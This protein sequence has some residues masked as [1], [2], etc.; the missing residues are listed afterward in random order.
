MQV[1]RTLVDILNAIDITR[2]P[3]RVACA[4]ADDENLLLS[5]RTTIARGL[6]KP[7]LIGPQSQIL[8][9]ASV[10]GLEAGT[11]EVIDIADKEEACAQ[12][13]FLCQQGE[14][15]VI[16]KGA[17]PTS[18]LL[19]AVLRSES[20]S[21]SRRTLTHVTVFRPRGFRRLMVLADAGVQIAPNTDDLTEIV[22]HAARLAC[23]LGIRRPKVAMLSAAEFINPKMPSSVIA[24]EVAGLCSARSDITADVGGPYALDVAVS[25]VA[26]RQKGMADGIAGRADVL[27]T[28]GID[29]GNVLYKSLTSFSGLDL[30]SVVVG[31]VMP[32]IIPSRADSERTKI[33]STA[34]AL[35][36]AQNAWKTPD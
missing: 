8:T 6:V 12:A 5:L 24:A 35:L 2:P 9:M 16:M 28:S 27:I 7:I 31:A 26:A 32:M 25:P 11:F 14:A 1:M 15:S 20:R 34:L 23:C 3:V 18:P 29:A 17:V 13:V 19:K 22:A 10:V 33:Y 36:L 30:A 4:A 21:Q